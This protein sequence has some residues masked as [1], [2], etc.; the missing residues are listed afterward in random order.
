M[1]ERTVTGRQFIA[2]V[3]TA[4]LS[5]LFR[6]LPRASAVLAGRAA[7]LCVLPAARNSVCVPKSKT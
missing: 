4:L 2:A 3:Y 7:F 1:K 5:P 6:L